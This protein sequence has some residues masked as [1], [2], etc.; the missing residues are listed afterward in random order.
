MHWLIPDGPGRGHNTNVLKVNGT[1]TLARG[2]GHATVG[3]YIQ[4][5]IF[6]MQGLLKLG[7]TQ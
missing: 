7:A 6:L 4:A 3:V 1:E 2:K 5:Q